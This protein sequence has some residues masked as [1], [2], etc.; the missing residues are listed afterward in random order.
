[1]L[2]ERNNRNR[3]YVLDKQ[4]KPSDLDHL[5]RLITTKSWWETVDSIDAFVGESFFE[6]DSLLTCLL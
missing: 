5:K 2:F 1:M 6:H 4:L 3:I